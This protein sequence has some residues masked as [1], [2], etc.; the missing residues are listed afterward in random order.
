V[1]LRWQPVEGAIGYLGHRADAPGGPFAPVDHLGGD[2]LLMSADT[3]RSEQVTGHFQ[4]GVL[5]LEFDLPQPGAAMI[6]VLA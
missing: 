2:V 4:D 3:L 5:M 1:T 6:E